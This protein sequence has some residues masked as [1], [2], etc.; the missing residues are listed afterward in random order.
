MVLT[1]TDSTTGYISIDL[2]IPRGSLGA[3]VAENSSPDGP[4][5][6]SVNNLLKENSLV[7]VGD[8]LES[9]D[10]V[11]F[12]K[13][14]SVQ[15][16]ASL[17][18]LT[19]NKPVR[20]LRVRRRRHIPSPAVQPSVTVPAPITA[21]VRPS[22]LAPPA[23]NPTLASRPI[24]VPQH[25]A[26]PAPIIMAP[27]Q[28]KPHPNTA[29]ATNINAAS[30][31]QVSTATTATT[32]PSKSSETTKKGVPGPTTI[33]KATTALKKADDKP[34][35][36]NALKRPRFEE[37]KIPAAK[38]STTK[39]TNDDKRRRTRNRGLRNLGTYEEVPSDFSPDR[40]DDD[41]DDA[42]SK[43]FGKGSKNNKKRKTEKTTK[44]PVK[45]EPRKQVVS[46][47]KVTAAPSIRSALESLKVIQAYCK[48][49]GIGEELIETLDIQIRNHW[50][51]KALQNDLPSIFE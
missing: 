22:I 13:K 27:N 29:I 47:F 41:D 32:I 49:E 34:K 3:V 44:P 18:K 10:G 40:S 8:V 6:F 9:L 37:K 48:T 31:K 38:N 42:L 30:A 25:K 43:Q 2:R 46:T 24:L 35:T 51:E 26:V 45:V 5:G 39:T 19:Q 4:S 16:C 12:P 28:H 17:F 21:P 7:H 33:T 23:Q 15:D 20:I 50:F 14:G 1:G 11:P 36:S